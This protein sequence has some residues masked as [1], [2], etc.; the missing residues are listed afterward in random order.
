MVWCQKHKKKKNNNHQSKP[1]WRCHQ[2]VLIILSR[3]FSAKVCFTFLTDPRQSPRASVRQQ[4]V[5]K[6]GSANTFSEVS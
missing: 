3:H 4:S 2:H 6:L 5:H 1:Q